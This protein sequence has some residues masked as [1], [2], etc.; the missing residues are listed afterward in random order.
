MDTRNTSINCHAEWHTLK[1]VVVGRADGARIPPHDRSLKAINYANMDIPVPEGMYPEQV[2]EE[3]NED[4]ERFVSVLKSRDIVVHRP[5]AKYLTDSEYYVYCPR[6]SFITVGN[7]II[8]APMPLRARYMENFAYQAIFLDKMKQGAKWISAPKGRLPDE[9]YEVESISKDRL[10]LNEIE[11]C[12]DAAN[13]LKCGKDILYLV[14]NSGNLLGAQWLEIILGSEYRVHRLENLY[15][16]M[17]LD[18]TISLL[19][20]GL[21][22]VNPSRI[23]KDNLPKIFKD[24]DVIYSADNVDIGH[25]PGY[26]NASVWIGINLLM[27]DE[28]TAVVEEH[29]TAVIKQLEGKGIDVCALPLRHSRTLGGGFHCITNDLY[30]QGTL[31]SYI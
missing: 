17:H 6:D 27:L 18:S 15:S 11:P 9:A 16:Y 12:F 8:E 24:W 22:L 1:E 26:C 4:L 23:N 2:I 21:V 28:K 20:P 25:Y 14:S 5:T 3:T 13:I 19:R 31:E 10:T 30:R 7:S 29:Q